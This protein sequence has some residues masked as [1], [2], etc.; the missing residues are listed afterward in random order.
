[1]K[2]LRLVGKSVLCVMATLALSACSD[3]DDSDEV[4]FKLSDYEVNYDANGAWADVYN[5][6]SGDVILGDFTFSH[7]ASG[8][9][10]D[11]ITYYS[12][13]GFCP[14]RSTDNADHTGDDWTL[15]QWGAI[16]GGGVS[17]K[18]TPYMLACWSTADGESIDA[19]S[20]S[21]RITYAGGKFDP[22]EVFVTNSTWGYYGMKN[23]TNYSKKFE[24]ADW[25]KL[26]I[27]GSLNGVE[28]GVVSV[29]LANGTDFLDTWQKVDL[30][31][32]GDVVDTIYFYMTSSDT[33][34]WG[35]N[36][37]AY[38]CLDRLTIDMI[39]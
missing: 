18:G 35:M 14:S 25:C 36:N 23:G 34:S 39:D 8:Y 5:V 32:L 11:G 20:A 3:D 7:E 12:Y 16:T 4:T 15:Y 22:D 17:G 26:H 2:T 38:F 21:L 27:V 28:T 6:N 30:D 9:E 13:K 19:S 31:A 1:M 10:W 24:E 33:G 37:P 29:M